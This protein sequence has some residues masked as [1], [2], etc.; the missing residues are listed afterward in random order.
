MTAQPGASR[1]ATDLYK[2]DFYAWTQEQATLLPMGDWDGYTAV[3]P[4]KLPNL[5]VKMSRLT[6][7][8]APQHL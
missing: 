2:A 8:H 3:Y 5:L 4:E 6:K 1:N 7:H